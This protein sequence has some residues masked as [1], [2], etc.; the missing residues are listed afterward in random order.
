[1]IEYVKGTTKGE[2]A[3][4]D[5]TNSV[6]ELG[7]VD[8][9]YTGDSVVETFVAS[10]TKLGFAPVVEGVFKSADGKTVLGDIAVTTGSTT[11]Y[12]TF[13]NEAS[14]KDGTLASMTFK[15]ADGTSTTHTFA[16][17]DKI[18]YK[19]DNVIIPQEELP[20]LKAQLNN[21]GLEAHARRIAVFYSQ[22]AAF[23]A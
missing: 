23:Q 6:W 1:M 16:A 12:G 19:Y 21:I 13:A 3:Q 4:G 10:Q 7:D 11:V 17:N 18:A 2:S 8:K 15:A 5:M 9:N 14:R 22:M 20:T